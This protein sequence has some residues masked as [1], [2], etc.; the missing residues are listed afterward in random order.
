VAKIQNSANSSNS[1]EV[2]LVFAPFGVLR[3]F[4]SI[5]L[6]LIDPSTISTQSEGCPL[7]VSL[8]DL[9]SFAFWRTCIW[10]TVMTSE[11]DIFEY[12]E[13]RPSHPEAV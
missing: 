2:Q 4:D 9:Q 13:G 1:V 11:D 10:V 5:S 12:Y 7:R 6:S 8:M 3:F